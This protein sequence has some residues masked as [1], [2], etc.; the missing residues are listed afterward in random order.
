MDE[1]T[2]RV[3]DII[4]DKVPETV[5]PDSDFSALGLDSLAMAEIVS[6][7]EHDFGITAD[8]EILEVNNI[9]ELVDYINDQRNRAVS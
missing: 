3:L 4:N 2:Q 9:R 5:Q 6:Q 1:T 7:V 8:Y